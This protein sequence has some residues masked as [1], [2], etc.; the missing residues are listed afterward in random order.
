MNE[1]DIK[2]DYNDKNCEQSDKAM[3][4]Q[5]SKKIF[6]S[7][8]VHKVGEN[9]EIKNINVNLHQLRTE[10]E[11][12]KSNRGDLISENKELKKKEDEDDDECEVA[13]EEDEYDEKIKDDN[14]R[15]EINKYGIKNMN[16]INNLIK[17]YNNIIN[18]DKSD[19]NNDNIKN[20][21]NEFK[22]PNENT[23]NIKSLN[24]NPIANNIYKMCE[25]CKH[26]YNLN[27]LFVAKCEEHYICKRS[28]KNYYE[29]A[30]EEGKK[31]LVCPF[32]TCKEEIDKNNR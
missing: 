30:I 27:K 17:E 25:I 29:E 18:N 20:I 16:N 23:R 1:K 6:D 21:K 3:N 7:I 15:K 32:L 4:D 24:I 5:V 2:R 14:N 19:K 28:T 10:N 9:N 26:T 22:E 12:E 11:E 8:K 13:D 31:G